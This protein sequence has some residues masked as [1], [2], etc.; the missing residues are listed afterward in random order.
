VLTQ[1]AAVS[2]LLASGSAASRPTQITSLGQLRS[3]CDDLQSN[4][5]K[6]RHGKAQPSDD[7]L[8]S[9]R[10]AAQEAELEVRLPPGQFHLSHVDVRTG[11]VTLDTQRSFLLFDGHAVLGSVERDDLDLSLNEGQTL[12]NNPESLTLDLVVRPGDDVEPICTVTASGEVSLGVEV[13]RASLLDRSGHAV[14]TL[15]SDDQN[16]P[17]AAVGGKPMVAFDSV[18]VEGD[19]AASAALTQALASLQTKLLGCFEV[20][21]KKT[22]T[23]DGTLVL[24][25]NLKG[26]GHLGPITVVADSVQDD[27]MVACVMDLAQV[28]TVSMAPKDKKEKSTSA[29]SGGRTSATLRFERR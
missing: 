21:L 23:L 10:A 5:V 6:R 1:V 19:D 29:A 20:A 2:L 18:Q 14:A 16:D 13:V 22:P 24:A 12:P 11:T 17:P 4:V 9:R 25:F 7:E 26:D 28:V 3:L 15:E 27:P 8:Q